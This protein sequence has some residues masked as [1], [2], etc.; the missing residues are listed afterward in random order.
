MN[1]VLG[2]GGVNLSGGQKQR[3]ALARA[4]LRNPKILILDDCTSALDA[5]TEAK[6]FSA[7]RRE[8]SGV[9]VFTVSQRI[10]AVRDCDR[11]LCMEAGKL[12]GLGT[13][14]ELMRDCDA[15]RAIYRSQIGSEKNA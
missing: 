13:H 7:L 12:C 5:L 15:Y 11:I 4:I 1:T 3:L 8:L 2:Q 14:D 6:V 9:T 10:S